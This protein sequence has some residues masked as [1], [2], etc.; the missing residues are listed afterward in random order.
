MK[1]T[2]N[3]K[4]WLS[5]KNNYDVL[6]L[7]QEYP[8]SDITDNILFYNQFWKKNKR[9]GLT[10]SYSERIVKNYW[11][12]KDNCEELMKDNCGI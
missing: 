10:V 11:S 6:F 2:K 8:Q 7:I 1:F 3:G 5:I 9:N 12:T 4:G